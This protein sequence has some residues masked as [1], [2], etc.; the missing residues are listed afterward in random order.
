[1]TIR[2]IDEKITST[3]LLIA[4]RKKELTLAEIKMEVDKV[5][6]L[7]DIRRS[8]EY[9]AATNDRQREAI[10]KPAMLRHTL[11]SRKQIAEME[12]EIDR[13]H[14]QRRHLDRQFAIA[15][16]EW[17]EAFNDALDARR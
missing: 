14:A 17:R 5:G 13:L 7:Q 1:M 4:R 6:A 12:E 3:E 16:G 10:E 2:E 9:I 11:F 15:L 8:E